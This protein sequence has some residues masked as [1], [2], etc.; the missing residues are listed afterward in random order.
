M[1]HYE[2]LLWRT[3]LHHYGPGAQLRAQK[4]IDAQKVCYMNDAYSACKG[5]QNCLRV[6]LLACILK[7]KHTGSIP[8]TTT[9]LKSG[10]AVDLSSIQVTGFVCLTLFPLVIYHCITAA[11]FSHVKNASS[12]YVDVSLRYVIILPFSLISAWD[13]LFLWV[14][15]GWW[16]DFSDPKA[17][18][19]RISL[20]CMWG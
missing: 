13:S 7:K 11:R 17:D 18:I 16:C 19:H 14:E 10:P 12:V 5:N 4:I 20:N 3:S 15:E 6:P 2:Y 1:W 9:G 8:E